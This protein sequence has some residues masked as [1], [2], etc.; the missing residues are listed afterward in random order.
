MNTITHTNPN[1]KTV[2]VSVGENVTI[3]SY[4]TIGENVT[5]GKNVTITPGS[6]VGSK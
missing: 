1:G 4:S 5:I 6:I 3:G 2:L